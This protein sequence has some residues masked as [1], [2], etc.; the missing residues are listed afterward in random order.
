MKKVAPR[1]RL[2]G[3]VG[4]LMGGRNV[5]S[6][7]EWMDKGRSENSAIDYGLRLRLMCHVKSIDDVEKYFDSIPPDAKNHYTYGAFLNCYCTKMMTDK[8]LA[9]FKKM[10]ELK[11]VFNNMPFNSLMDLYIKVGTPEKVPLLV[12]EMKQRKIPL[13]NLTYYI[14]IQSYRHAVDLEGL[15]Q[16][17][18]EVQEQDSVRDDWK[19]YSNLAAVYIEAHQ[20]EEAN[21][22]LKRMEELFDNPRSADRKAYHYLISMYAKTGNL[23][24]VYKAWEKLVSNFE[25]CQNASYLTMLRAL[26]ALDD[27]EGLKKLLEEWEMGCLAYDERLPAVVIGAYLRHDMLEEA[28][29]LL[30]DIKVKAD[31]QIK[32]AHVL[33]MNYFLEKH[34][35][36]SALKHMEA[37]MAAKWKPVVEKLDP[38]FNHFKEEKNVDSAEDFCQ[39]LEKVQPLDSRTYLWLLQTYAAAGQI[40]PNMRQRMEGSGID[41]T[42]EHEELL[43]KIC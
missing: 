16:V 13:T 14:W 17:M 3:Q 12:E 43:Q 38:F 27:I 9:V 39:K 15:E 34:Q 41:I 7:L 6:I 33:F 8:A 19:I 5:K 37:A 31:R 40:A 18:H 30:R 20:S 11:Y 26:S 10:D 4:G 23:S 25:V 28:E 22:A 35:F 42:P 21:T 2:G 36:D 32:F 29:Q 24:S 1:R